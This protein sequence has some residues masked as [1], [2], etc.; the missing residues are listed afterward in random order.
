[1]HWNCENRTENERTLLSPPPQYHGISGICEVIFPL[2]RPDIFS[3]KEPVVRPSTSAWNAL[4]P[5]QHG[6]LRPMQS[7]LIDSVAGMKSIQNHSVSWCLHAFIYWLSCLQTFKNI[8]FFGLHLELNMIELAIDHVGICCIKSDI[9]VFIWK[10]IAHLIHWF[11]VM[12]P[13]Q[14]AILHWI[15][16]FQTPPYAIILLD[17]VSLDNVFHVRYSPKL[18]KP[19]AV[20]QDCDPHVNRFPLLKLGLLDM[21]VV[22][23]LGIHQADAD[24]QR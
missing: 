13:I 1:M 7:L 8:R 21:V 15:S 17:H 14:I 9:D 11:I 3:C 12:F 6:A 18:A 19:W 10:G 5:H 4:R 2:F 16:D 23:L 22:H 24:Q 20:F